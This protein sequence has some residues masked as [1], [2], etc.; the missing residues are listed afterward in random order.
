MNAY[1]DLINSRAKRSAPQLLEALEDLLED[2]Q[3][4]EHR[5]G[6]PCCPVDSARRI[7]ALVKTGKSQPPT[8][9]EKP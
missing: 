4:A 9:S 7:V 2:T 1:D 3:H 8:A 6:D 5:C